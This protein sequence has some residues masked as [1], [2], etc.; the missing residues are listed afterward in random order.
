VVVIVWVHGAIGLYSTLVLRPV[1]PRLAPIV[2]P[3]LF[4]VPILA[5][6]GF[7]HAGDGVLARLA[8]DAGWRAL[9]EQ[10][11]QVLQ[12]LGYR[13]HVIETGIFLVYGGAVALAVGIFAANILRRRSRGVASQ[14]QRAGSGVIDGTSRAIS[15]ALHLNPILDGVVCANADRQ[16]ASRATGAFATVAA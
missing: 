1:W 11:L 7:A 14:C 10:N 13:L 6:L 4:A 12:E 3:V 8:N 5:L 2:I 15:E 9:V 16:Y